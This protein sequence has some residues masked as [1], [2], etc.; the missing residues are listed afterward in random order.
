MEKTTKKSVTAT[1]LEI[2]SSEIIALK[3]KNSMTITK[4]LNMFYDIM[5]KHGIKQGTKSGNGIRKNNY[6]W[7]ICWTLFASQLQSHF[8]W[9]NLF[10]VPKDLNNY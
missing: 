2:V 1:K 9:T 6:E 5:R 4:A 8:M 7:T 3:F 10:T